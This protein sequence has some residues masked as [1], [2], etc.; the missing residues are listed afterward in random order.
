MRVA[1]AAL[2][3]VSALAGCAREAESVEG[4]SVRVFVMD[5]PDGASPLRIEFGADPVAKPAALRV[6]AEDDETNRQL[7]TRALEAA[8]NTTEGVDVDAPPS[9][10]LLVRLELSGAPAW[11]HVRVNA[12]GGAVLLDERLFVRPS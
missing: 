7:T 8:T 12:A 6:V 4:A 1:I 2:L 5:V 10:R 3:I 11:V 9:G